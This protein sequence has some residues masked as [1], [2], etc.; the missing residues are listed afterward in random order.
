MSRFQSLFLVEEG[1]E[2]LKKQVHVGKEKFSI[3]LAHSRNPKD[4]TSTAVATTTT[5]ATYY[6]YFY[7]KQ[8]S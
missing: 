2:N 8:E 1:N 6:Y 3:V 4:V 7:Y 5:A